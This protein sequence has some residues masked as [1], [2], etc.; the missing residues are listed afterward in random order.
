MKNKPWQ[1]GKSQNQSF[2]RMKELLVSKK[3]LTYY[4]VQKPVKIQVDASKSGLGTILLQDDRPTAYV[5]KSLTP[6]QQRYAPIEQEMLAAVYGCQR[7]HEYIYGKKVTIQSD[8][9]PLEA[10][11]KKPLQ[12][13]PPQLQIMLLSL[14]K[15]D[16]DLVYLAGKENILANT[17]SRAHLEETADDIPEKEL[18][19]QVHIV[20][21]NPPATKSRLEEIKEQTAKDAA[22]KKITKYII[23]GW[24]NSKENIVNEAKSYWS[25]REELSIINGI[26]FK[27]E[28]LLIPEVMR[29]K[30][31]EELHQTHKGIEQTKWRAGA[32]IS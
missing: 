28:R 22:L 30:V 1:W 12:N 15:Y 3:Y 10:I 6:S 27:S 16:V 31:L 8:L 9:R 32:T 11:M 17:L 13:T 25:F 2:E 20:Y 24:P 19:A 26:V 29:K 5:S 7:F 23:E 18:T 14:Q 21:E 4:Y